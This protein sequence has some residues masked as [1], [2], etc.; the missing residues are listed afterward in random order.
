MRI[1]YNN[2]S[3][4]IRKCLIKVHNYVSKSTIDSFYIL[5]LLL[6]YLCDI[7]KLDYKE[8]ILDE[9]ISIVFNKIK[10]EY[11]L[12]FGY[13]HFINNTSNKLLALI[14]YE[15]IKE[16]VYD[17]LEANRKIGINLI[18]KAINNTCILR[19]FDLCNYNSFG[20]TT[21]I[22]T[23]DSYEKDAVAKFKI[24]DLILGVTNKY[25]YNGKIDNNVVF[26]KAENPLYRLAKND[27][28]LEDVYKIIKENDIKIILKT[29]YKKISTF[30]D[31]ELLNYY[32]SKVLINEDNNENEAI[33][34]F[35]K[36]KD[37]NISILL[38]NNNDNIDDLRERI[39]NNKEGNRLVKVKIDTIVNNGYRLGFK[40]YK[41]EV[42]EEVKGINDLVDK[43]RYLMDRL[44]RINED[45]E[46]EI[47]KLIVK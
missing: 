23:A 11:G 7:G 16:L 44:K 14:Q 42:K 33:I 9:D 29:Q 19:H 24:F 12:L 43:N 35:E 17:F 32:V 20:G 45:I 15:N 46:G 26:I 21:Y 36:R 2:L 1:M 37:D 10:D 4:E 27:R 40:I 39:E 47:N 34:I 25:L 8:I 38:Y 13:T 41:N 22:Y 3:E 30:K 28:V 5:L 31:K 6:K 18:D